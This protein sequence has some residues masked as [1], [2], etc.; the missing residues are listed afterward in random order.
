M[1]RRGLARSRASGRSQTVEVRGLKEAA[2]SHGG[3]G[4]S[5]GSGIAGPESSRRVR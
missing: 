1:E 3:G 5:G 2:Q 4:G